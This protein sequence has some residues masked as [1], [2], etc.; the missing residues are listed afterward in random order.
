MDVKIILNKTITL[1]GAIKISAPPKG[2][3]TN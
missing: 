3:P 2:S 1:K